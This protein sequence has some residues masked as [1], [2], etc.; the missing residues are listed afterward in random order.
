MRYREPLWTALVLL[1]GLLALIIGIAMNADGQNFPDS[2]SFWTLRDGTQALSNKDVLRSKKWWIPTATMFTATLWDAETTHAGIGR[3]VCLE[4]NTND[5]G[6]RPSRGQLYQNMLIE[7][8]A[9][10]GLGFLFTKVKAWHWIYDGMAG[11]G[12][13]IHVKGAISWY[14]KC[15]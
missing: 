15:W 1:L 7:D 8:G 10:A 6:L 14:T 13:V 3:H 9:I 5:Y 2:P 4:G 11:Y 12:T